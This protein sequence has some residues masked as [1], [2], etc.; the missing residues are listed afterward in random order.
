M[1]KSI[2]V[3]IPTFNECESIPE[4]VSTLQDVLK[5]YKKW[6]IL[7]SIYFQSAIHIMDFNIGY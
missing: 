2:S 1:N 3:V 5:P 7:L 4:L 6:E